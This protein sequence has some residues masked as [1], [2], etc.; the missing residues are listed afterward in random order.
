MSMG[1]LKMASIFPFFKIYVEANV[2]QP[3]WGLPIGQNLVSEGL[4][5]EGIS[6][7]KTMTEISI[8]RF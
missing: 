6:A 7:E 1:L 3:F 8:S 5:N 2:F 4:R